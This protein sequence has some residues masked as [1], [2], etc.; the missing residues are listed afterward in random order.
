MISLSEAWGVFVRL[1]LPPS[2]TL[3]V[4]VTGVLVSLWLSFPQGIREIAVAAFT[5]F[6]IDTVTGSWLALKDK[7]FASRCFG[8]SLT[9]FIVYLLALSAAVPMGT[10]LHL[11]DTLLL[12]VLFLVATRE[13]SSVVEN[14]SDL[15]FPWP[16]WILERL[17][18]IEDSCNIDPTPAEGETNDGGNVQ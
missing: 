5:L 8:R 17:K 1:V 3:L 6:I 14:T 10:V 18:K 4:S 11:E 12:I 16:K 2:R 13:G 7:R 15:G 9:K